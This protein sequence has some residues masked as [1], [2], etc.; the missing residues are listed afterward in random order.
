MLKALAR[1]QVGTRLK[2]QQVASGHR[3]AGA[4]Q[5]LMIDLKLG[6]ARRGLIHRPGGLVTRLQVAFTGPGGKPLHAELQSR[7]LV[8]RRRAKQRVEGAGR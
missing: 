1:S 3:R 2:T 6:H 8:H 5:T 4:A 7:F